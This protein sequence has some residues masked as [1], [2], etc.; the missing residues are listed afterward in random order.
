MG[1]VKNAGRLEMKKLTVLL[2][3][4][5]LFCG[6]SNKIS[7][8]E[9]KLDVVC[10]VYPAYDWIKEIAKDTD[11]NIS[12]IPSNGTDIHSYQPN[13]DDIIKI[14]GCD[15]FIYSSAGE[16]AWYNEINIPEDKKMNI[17]QFCESKHNKD[18]HIWMSPD[19]VSDIVQAI[20]HKLCML[21]PSFSSVYIKNEEKYEEKLEILD[22]DFENILDEAKKRIILVADRFP[23]HHLTEEYGIK[24]FSAFEGCSAESEVSFETIAYLSNKAREFDINAVIVTEKSDKRIA[25]AIIENISEKNIKILELNSMQSVSLKELNSGISYL[26]VMRENLKTLKEALN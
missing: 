13:A 22:E 20:S 19:A 23:F 18:E 8:K 5:L 10:T 24:H 14:T 26:S 9:D 1:H 4:L 25:N 12:L 2:I 7:Y 17:T 16:K 15:L 21:N 11:I 6:C 3:S